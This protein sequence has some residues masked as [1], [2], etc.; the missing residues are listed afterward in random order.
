V[1]VDVFTEQR[2]QGNQLAVFP[3]VDETRVTAA[4]LQAL[5]LELS[6]SETTFVVGRDGAGGAR[7]RIFTP[8][9]ELPFAGH[10]ALGTAAVVAPGGGTVRLAL[11][12]GPVPV[13]VAVTS[14]GWRAELTAPPARKV[15][16]AGSGAQQAGS[17]AVA[18]LAGSAAVA[19]LGA[20]AELAAV[21]AVAELAATVGLDEAALDPGLPVEAWS[22]GNPFVLMPV[23]DGAAVARAVP[24]SRP[25]APGDALGIVVFA[26]DGTTVHAR[27]LIPGS[28]VPED[29]ATGSANA[30]LCAYLHRH[31]RLALGETLTTTQGVEMGRPSRLWA[32]LERDSDGELR[33]R[34]AG[35]VV[36]VGEGAFD[37]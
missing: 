8:E 9:V 33:P 4:E 22:C 32:R 10:P 27:V 11:G 26:V 17:A 13:V 23:R 2:F 15:A 36:R 5:A 6:L 30:P 16:L 12:V 3:D 1:L 34:V 28:R 19:E 31:G 21:A 35:G 24:S 29:P 7:V 18:E 25:P 37:L 20:V 14:Y